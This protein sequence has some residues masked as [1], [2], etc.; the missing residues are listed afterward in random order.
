[1]ESF[2][3][4]TIITQRFSNKLHNWAADKRG[5]VAI[6]FAFIGLPLFLLL[7]GAI[8]IA[9]IF[10]ISTTLENALNEASRQ[11]R[12]GSFQS[13][14]LSET[15]FRTSLCAEFFDLLSCDT[16]LSIDVRPLTGFGASAPPPL[17]SDGNLNEGSFSFDAG[18][19]ND[20]ILV[21]AFYE[22]E[23]FTPILTAP[24]ANLT[25]NTRLI[26]SGVAF[27]NEPF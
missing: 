3:K 11:I 1:M 23:L 14:D 2:L 6:E 12:T 10:L 22:W 7:F 27:R 20:I 16:R 25:P 5:S 4:Y 26:Q 18:S 17:D 24:F 21:R 19:S 9:F 13:A 15:E 8:E